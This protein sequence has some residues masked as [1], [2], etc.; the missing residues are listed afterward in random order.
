MSLVIAIAV[1]LLVTVLLGLGVSW[2]EQDMHER[3]NDWHDD[4]S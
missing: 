4:W 1:T 2:L 3:L